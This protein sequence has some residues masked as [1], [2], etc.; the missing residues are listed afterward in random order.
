MW[1]CFVAM[2]H[3][4]LVR[5]GCLTSSFMWGESHF[6]YINN[7]SVIPANCKNCVWRLFD[8]F[9]ICRHISPMGVAGMSR[10]GGLCQV[11]QRKAVKL[12]VHDIT[13]HWDY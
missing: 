5:L 10:L 11:W 13:L 7:V 9:S 6:F 1:C 12:F 8:F 3:L 4:R 2:H